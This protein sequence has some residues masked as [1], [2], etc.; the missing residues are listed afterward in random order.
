MLIFEA[1]NAQHGDAIILQWGAPDQLKTAV[2]DGGPSGTWSKTLRPR[3]RQ[4]AALPG[5]APHLAFVAVSHID[6]DHIDGILR[7]LHELYD[8]KVASYEPPYQVDRFW[9]NSLDDLVSGGRP[10]THALARDIEAEL[11]R[12]A[13][14]NAIGQSVAQ[15]REARDLA[16]FLDLSGNPPLQDVLHSGQRTDIDGLS[17][18]VVAP[19][20][21]ELEAQWSKWRQAVDRADAKAVAAAF[22]DRNVYNQASIVLLVDCDDVRLLLTG[23]ARGDKL[24]AALDETGAL[25]SDGRMHVDLFKVPHHGSIANAQLRL[26][27]AI[28]A[29]HYV[30]SA[31]GKHGHPDPAV[32]DW[33][34]QSRRGEP[35]TLH[36]T[37]AITQPYDVGEHLKEH[38]AG[39]LFDVNVRPEGHAGVRVVFGE[40]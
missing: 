22:S 29:D 25:D 33:I 15:G 36:L 5:T 3:L 2:V 37:N 17:V 40:Q 19:R 12:T 11:R 13:E 23:D 10:L 16:S 20:Q 14:G 31:S 21:A 39:V 27:E 26:F 32:L 8:A 7:L 18:L 1:L 30:I 6:S 35:F 24:L 9:H 4:L 28:T 38:G 34:V